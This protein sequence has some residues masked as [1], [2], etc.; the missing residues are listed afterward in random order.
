VHSITVF[1][2]GIPVPDLFRVR[3]E[4]QI[5]ELGGAMGR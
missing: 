4:Q 5:E 2:W 1:P 3:V